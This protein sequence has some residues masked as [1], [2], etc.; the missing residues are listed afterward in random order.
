MLTYE[1]RSLCEAYGFKQ[2]AFFFKA[3]QNEDFTL[4]S[5]ESSKLQDGWSGVTTLRTQRKVVIK[6]DGKHATKFPK[7]QKSFHTHFD[8]KSRRNSGKFH[9][10]NLFA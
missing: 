2:N 4:A 6:D 10:F 1:I 7:M 9:T 3:S 8:L 5:P